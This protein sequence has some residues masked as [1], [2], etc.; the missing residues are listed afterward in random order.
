MIISFCIHA[1]LTWA[2]IVATIQDR[3]MTGS[4]GR[5][6][7]EKKF[8]G[9]YEL[10]PAQKTYPASPARTRVAKLLDAYLAEVARDSKLPLAKFQSLAEALP[11]SSRASDDGL[12]KAIDTYL[13]IHPGLAEHEK[14]KL[15]RVLDCQRLSL[16][17]C[18]HAAQNERLPL[19]VVVQVTNLAISSK[20]SFGLV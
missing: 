12:Y 4:P 8:T 9:I 19:R 18:L 6:S 11:E 15:C 16:D 7:F 20:L 13:K 17:A 5:Q 10:S 2:L 14:K 3:G 1:I